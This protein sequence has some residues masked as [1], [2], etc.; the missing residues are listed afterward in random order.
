MEI[1]PEHPLVS[2]AV[3][4][5]N[6]AEYIL[7]TLESVKAQ[8][9]DNIELV[10]SDDCSKDNTVELCRQWIME[11]R[12]RF[13]A[14]HIVQSP[15]N[16][17]Q[18]GN[19]NRAFDAC[20]G[21]WIK[22]IDGDDK[23]LP[24]CVSDYIEFTQ[25][26]PDSKYI[27]GKMEYI[28]DAEV[29]ASVKKWF[30]YN[31]FSMTTEQQLH[32]LLYDGNCVPSPSSFYNR[33]FIKAIGFRNDERIPYLED[34]PKWINLLR[35]GVRFHLMDKVVAEYR[36]GNGISTGGKQSVA[37]YKTGLLFDYYY[38]FPAWYAD[39]N[40]AAVNRMVNAQVELYEHKL[41]L[42]DEI[43]RLRETKAYRL[44]KLILKPFSWLKKKERIA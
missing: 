25:S 35:K 40:E 3:I 7:E 10:I 6:S 30:D 8:T 31:F 44:G 2:V 16:T 20:K 38:R 37:F 29:V 24:N 17:G 21:E 15:V 33:E 43:K 27:F 4:A 22:E 34:Y 42:E 11:N 14:V 13:S 1:N 41:Q 9:Y 18:S 32:R 26:H 28:G 23:L 5:Y 12:S 39:D 19:Y 36:V